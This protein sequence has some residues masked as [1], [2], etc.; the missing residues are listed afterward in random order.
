[1]FDQWINVNKNGTVGTHSIGRWIC[2]SCEIK[3]DRENRVH[4]KSLKNTAYSGK[5]ICRKCIS[6]FINVTDEYKLKQRT[7]QLKSYELCPER[8]QNIS[9]TLI[10]NKINVGEK[11]GMKSVEARKKVSDSRKHMNSKNRKIYSDATRRAWAEGKFAGVKV[12]RC[13]WYAINTPN[14]PM[15]VQ[16]TWELKYAE[17][18]LENNISFYAHRG[19]ISYKDLQEATHSYYPDFYL[20]DDDRYIDIKAPYFYK[21]GREKFNLIKQQYPELK[22]DIIEYKKNT[23]TWEFL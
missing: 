12:G 21:L 22:L 14:G 6:K 8:R 19:R 5:D 15:K 23:N 4:I 9:K 7:A 18:L 1:M 2:D 20:P 16:G 11:N 3:F 17:Y 10:E 13:K